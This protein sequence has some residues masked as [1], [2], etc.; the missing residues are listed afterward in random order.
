MRVH[1]EFLA[2]QKIPEECLTKS[3]WDERFQDIRNFERLPPTEWDDCIKIFSTL[4]ER[5]ATE[6]FPRAT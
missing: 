5:R 2:G 3:I 6:A 4:I 1:P